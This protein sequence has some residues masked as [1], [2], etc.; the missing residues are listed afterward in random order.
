VG[1]TA[2]AVEFGDLFRGAKL[3]SIVVTRGLTS[4]GL[5]HRLRVGRKREQRWMKGPRGLT[6][7]AEKEWA[8]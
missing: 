5:D 3:R 4:G 1:S 8:R 7:V 2:A 6:W